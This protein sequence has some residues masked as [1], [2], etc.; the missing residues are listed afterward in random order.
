MARLAFKKQRNRCTK[1][2]RQ[3]KREYFEKVTQNGG[4]RFWEVLKPFVTDKGSHGNEEFILEE[5]GEL[6]KDPVQVSNIFNSY[7]TNIVEHTT[8]NPPIQI[9]LSETSGIIDDILSYYENHASILSIKE[10]CTNIS[11]K[12]PHPTEEE[13]LDI[14]NSID[15]KKA[16]GV[17]NIPPKVIKMA[18]NIIKTP[19]CKI[20]KLHIIRNTFPNLMKIG[21]LSPIYKNPKMGSRL[22]KKY[23]RPVSVLTIFSKVFERFVL[24]S[25][26]EY[27]NRIL[28]DHISAYRKGYSCQDVL[29]KLT[30]E[31]RK[32]L[33]NNEVVGAVLMDL[34]KAFDCLPH[35]LLIAKLSA[36]GF[37]KETL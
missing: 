3:S 36:Y 31:W 24:N 18:A 26:L 34:S 22:D 13:I 7:F 29:L 37:E 30:E 28:S 8:G 33:D 35:E 25:M 27:V 10:K 14:I 32:H 20:M 17:D 4:K 15:I 1:L 12:I 5:N 21:R 9:P 6:I 23:F 2:L 11:F 16:T 19:L